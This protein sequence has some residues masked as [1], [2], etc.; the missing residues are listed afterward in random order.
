MRPIIHLPEGAQTPSG[1]W[2]PTGYADR[3][4]PGPP[5]LTLHDAQASGLAIISRRQSDLLDVLFHAVPVEEDVG[6]STSTLR[7]LRLM[8]T[9]LPFDTA[10]VLFARL[11]AETWHIGT[12]KVR[13]LAL[14]RDL[15]PFGA[16]VL[17]ALERF[18]NQHDRGAVFAEQQLFALMRMTLA[19]SPAGAVDESD[20]AA[21][22]AFSTA[23]FRS[24][25]AALTVVTKSISEIP[26]ADADRRKWLA[27]LVQN[28]GY[29]SKS[30]PLP[31]FT[32]ARLLL[33]LAAREKSGDSHNHCDVSG[34]LER[35][36]VLTPE[37]QFALGFSLLANGGAMSEDHPVGE[38][39]L[40]PAQRVDGVV[41][42]LGLSDRKDE[43]L[44][45]ISAPREWYAE[46]FARGKETAMDVAWRRTPFEQ[47]PFLQWGDGHLL[48]LSPRALLSW[49]GE[50]FHH[51]VFACAER[52]GKAMRARY[53]R[54]HGELVEAYA[55]ELVESVYPAPEPLRRVHGEQS[56]R[57]KDGESKTSD[58]S[59]D[60]APDLVLFEVTAARLTEK[61]RVV[62][63]WDSVEFDLKKLVLERI[64]KL[65]G[66]VTALLDGTATIP[67]VD[68]SRIR[69]IWPVIV[70]AGD[71]VQSDLL[72]D[73]VNEH[74]AGRLKQRPVQALTMVDLDDFELL[75]GLV[76]GGMSLVEV[77]RR[78]AE[79]PFRRLDLS[80]WRSHDPTAPPGEHPRALKMKMNAVFAETVERLGFDPA[81]MP[82]DPDD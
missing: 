11:S 70:T 63:D 12:D 65:D 28:G 19:H 51:R 46:R 26:G 39:S 45:L 3:T 2:L 27:V 66:C 79:S 44:E 34:W 10:M 72:W 7:D 59:V 53:Q 68:G 23:A 38:R 49:L 73:Y 33:E 71:L 25:F 22:H 69:H 60:S 56:Y 21:M 64:R 58:I 24:L 30:E 57:S 81:L 47:R 42:Q 43:T 9:R 82:V 50:G 52:R 20:P 16:P 18:M 78:K 32:R 61:T 4:E 37:E 5:R 40:I 17:T 14:A 48:L 13:Q 62:A 80:Q 75:M 76:E 8:V 15:F 54:F 67:H 77:L 41:Q 1:L 35:D 29:N 55:L 36:Y 74:M 6:L 31:A